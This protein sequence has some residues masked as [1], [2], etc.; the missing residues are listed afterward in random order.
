M[1]VQMTIVMKKIEN[2][3]F[4]KHFCNAVGNIMCV[5]FVSH[6]SACAA[7]YILKTVFYILGRARWC[8]LKDRSMSL[9]WKK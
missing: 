3:V 5:F 7:V 6:V 4:R 9:S 8:A 1:V 2:I